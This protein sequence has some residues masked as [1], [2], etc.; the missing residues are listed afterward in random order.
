[1]QKSAEKLLYL[2]EKYLVSCDQWER[3]LTRAANDGYANKKDEADAHRAVQTNY[4]LPLMQE[5]MDEGFKYVD[6]MGIVAPPF[7]TSSEERQEIFE[8]L[9]NWAET[10][11]G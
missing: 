2:L 11:Y 3:H 6:L 5:C 7:K 9:R 1:M 8:D 10:K 4:Q